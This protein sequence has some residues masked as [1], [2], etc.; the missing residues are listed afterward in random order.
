MT[1]QV[2]DQV[3][4]RPGV[5]LIPV[6]IPAGKGAEKLVNFL[7]SQ[8]RFTCPLI[9][10]SGYITKLGVQWGASRLPHQTRVT[11]SGAAWAFSPLAS[12][13]RGGEIVDTRGGTTPSFSY[14]KL[15]KSLE[16][17]R[18]WRSTWGQNSP[19]WQPQMITLCS[20]P[21]PPQPWGHCFLETNQPRKQNDLWFWNLRGLF[22]HSGS[23]F[24]LLS[25][26]MP[27][28]LGLHRKFLWE[29]MRAHKGEEV[30]M[31][32]GLQGDSSLFPHQFLIFPLP[33]NCVDNCKSSL[34]RF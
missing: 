4:Q 7:C 18:V 16:S 2:G 3:R 12:W 33:T 27:R 9:S 17:R 1:Q 32:L 6:S 30:R 21:G 31:D 34:L 23:F 11:A 24:E 28:Q 29:W 13:T 25:L 14:F 26:F 19:T 5:H 22:G 15:A 8:I 20:E 10:V